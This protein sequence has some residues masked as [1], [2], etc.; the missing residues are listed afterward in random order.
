[1][2]QKKPTTIYA[3]SCPKEKMEFEL[4]GE[5]FYIPSV[6]ARQ[7]CDVLPL[8]PGTLRRVVRSAV[9]SEGFRV[10]LSGIEGNAV[11]VTNENV[12]DLSA[13]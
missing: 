13:L 9:S 1:M 11:E 12:D 3:M 2:A 8:N 4:R 10:F 6:M 7:V 5:V